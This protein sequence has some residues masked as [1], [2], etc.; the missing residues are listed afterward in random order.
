MTSNALYCLAMSSS[1]NWHLDEALRQ[2]ALDEAK[3][4][5]FSTAP[6]IDFVFKGLVQVTGTARRVDTDVVNKVLRDLRLQA[7]EKG[8]NG[9]V[10]LRIEHSYS[11]VMQELFIT[12]YGDA[13]LL[14]HDLVG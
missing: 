12:A 1:D 9:I 5:L 10:G 11:D 3:I 7:L 13:V 8:A 2:S 6:A 14:P 4:E